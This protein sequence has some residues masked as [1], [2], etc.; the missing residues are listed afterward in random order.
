MVRSFTAE[1]EMEGLLQRFNDQDSL[2][3]LVFSD[4][5]DA[6]NKLKSESA[7]SRRLALLEELERKSRG[8]CIMR[9]QGAG[10]SRAEAHKLTEDASVGAPDPEL[11]AR[12]DRPLALLTAELGSG[13][14]LTSERLLQEAIARAR[15]ESDAPVQCT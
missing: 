15:K 6:V 11:R 5:T 9:W 2:R 14:S 13:K 7:E 1:L 10:L 8:R 12:L 4:L 3:S